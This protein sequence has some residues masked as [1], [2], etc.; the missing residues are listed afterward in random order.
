MQNRNSKKN[1]SVIFTLLLTLFFNSAYAES[2]SEGVHTRIHHPYQSIRAMGM[3]NAF[4]AVTDDYS[5]LFYNPAALG[6]RDDGE[7]NLSL[8]LGAGL[9]FA[10]I[11]KDLLGVKIEGTEAEK[12]AQYQD[13]LAKFYGKP[14][15]LRLSLLEAVWVRPGWGVGIL[16]AEFTFE[17]KFHNQVGPALN[18][19]SYLDSTVAYGYGDKWR[20]LPWGKWHW[21]VTGK[22]VNRGYVNKQVSALDLAADSKVLK[23]SDARDGYTVDADLG[24]LFTPFIPAD[25]IL[26]AFNLA[27]PTFGLVVRNIAET[28]FK[29]SFKLLNKDQDSVVPP[30]KLY[31]VIDVGAKFEYPQLW[32]FGG[33][34]AIDF[35]D[36]MHPDISFKKSLN[37]GFEFD[38]TIANWWRGAYRVGYSQGY[39]TA[40]ISAKLLLFNLDLA[41]YSEE[42]GTKSNPKE[43]RMIMSRMSLNF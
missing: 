24:L 25:G 39:L 23:T 36:L 35:K 9:G 12:F 27:K 7:I 38:W 17:G 11:Q 34:G 10:E 16:P 33:R 43:N 19:R 30:E 18:V 28:G 1:L 21:G 14:F 6:L 32:I 40:G 13:I 15:Q 26:S 4:V 2:D 29:Q 37:L 42:V 3:G 20:G 31:R 22:F 41:T 8:G 5:A